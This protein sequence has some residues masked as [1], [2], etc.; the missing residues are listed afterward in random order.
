MI[1]EHPS[2][3]LGGESAQAASQ[4]WD[5]LTLLIAAAYL[6]LTATAASAFDAR[7]GQF[8]GFKSFS[9]FE[10]SPGARAGE[11]VLTS[12]TIMGLI[13][14]DELIV[15]W[16]V[17]TPDSTYLKVEA[18]ALCSAGP[19]R[20]YTMGLWSVNTNHY[21]RESVLNQKDANGDVATDTL[22]LKLP[23]RGLQVRLT[24]GG[25]LDQK[26]ILKF[27][28]LQLTD[29]AVRPS[30]LPSKPAAL[31]KTIPVPQRSQMAYTNGSVLCSPTVVS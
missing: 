22:M 24:L 6:L 26:P 20:Y 3:H 12:P 25:D 19:T 31:G 5:R 28:G 8:I 17:E 27:I 2:R 10:Q 13:N 29:T 1:Y 4:R 30:A 11:I 16:N 9:A 21:P 18:R 7:G 15:S 14:W 23:G